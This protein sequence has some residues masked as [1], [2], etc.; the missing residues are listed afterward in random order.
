MRIPRPEDEFIK[1]LNKAI[2]ACQQLKD[3]VNKK[4]DKMLKAYVSSYY[5]K[6]VK[7]D[8][9]PLNMIYRTVSI[10]LPFLAG[11][12]PKNI[13]EPKTNLKLKPFAYIYQLALNQWMKDMKFVERTLLPVVF[14]SLF[15]RGIVKTGT[16]RADTAK[17]SGYLT[18]TGKPYAEV[19]D[20]NNYIFD[21]TAKDRTQYE[22][23][24][25][26]YLLPTDEAKEMYPKFAD[27]LQP[28]FKL[29]GEEHPKEIMNVGKIPYNK[30]REYSEFIDLWL[31]KE[32]V[33]I[34]ILPPNKG[35]AKI[36]K[37]IPY[38]GPSDGPYDE[39]GYNFISSSTIPI[40]PIYNLME[41]DTAINTLYV[42]AREGAESLKKIGA[43]EAGNEKDAETA[44]TA[45]NA[46]MYGFTNAAA[47]RELTLGG[48][49]PEVWDFL[50]FTLNQFS[51]QAGITGLDYRTRG[52]TLGQEQ[53]L[54]SNASRTLNYMS[55]K[56]H[57]FAVSIVEKLAWEMWRNPTLQISSTIKAPGIGQA[58]VTY[59]QL[60]QQ[61]DFNDYS[62][63]VEMFSMQ[64]LNPEERFQ[65][66]WQLLTGWI[67]PT[68]SISAQQGKIPNIPE[69]T[70][71]LSLYL[72]I[73]TEGW[74]LTDMP[75]YQQM[76][77]YQPVGG[78]KSADT[79]FGSNEGD[80][81]NNFLQS[82]M[83]SLGRT[84]K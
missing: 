73:D 15:S 59:N 42:K 10:W 25:D 28:D 29:Y 12:S 1:K 26:K 27:K 75:Q 62:F 14:N 2:S 47:I 24:G 84:T 30:L 21:I 31:P 37:T 78:V 76:N 66:M 70:R 65:K 32:G 58:S 4:N 16:A 56:V 54:M 48:P 53:I 41:M 55:Q 61:G 33:I 67:M 45:K 18:V 23:E 40:P 80:N 8:P 63:D 60:E 72:G 13:T 7:R 64:R 71:T 6:V 69:I 83:A 43:Y 5:Q 22:F 68:A 36:L 52:R 11:G 44:R 35:F 49:S 39:L 50:N 79:R 46:G 34:T 82:Q 9:H 20:D 51:E 57:S 17:L 74:Y 38:E 19:V 77:P 81:M 3:S